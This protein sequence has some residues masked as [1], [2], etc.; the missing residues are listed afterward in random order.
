MFL[1][2]DRY[3][4]SVLKIDAPWLAAHGIKALLIDIDNT[5]VARDKQQIIPEIRDWAAGLK[6]QG[7]QL[8]LVS[9]NWHKVVFQTAAGL[10]LPVIYKSMK[11]LPFAFMKALRQ[12]GVS[13]RQAAV[14]GDQM[15][16]DVLGA[17]LL[18]ARVIMV[19]PLST[20]DLAH[21]RFFRHFER[22][23]MKGR[24]PEDLLVGGGTTAGPGD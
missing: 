8:H 17:R 1:A 23:V 22:M 13:R 20:A 15:M 19:Q 6:S 4:S 7:F 18:G 5:M 12:M 24:I 10:G 3:L 14:V 11:P 16:T 21:T 2:P 9:N